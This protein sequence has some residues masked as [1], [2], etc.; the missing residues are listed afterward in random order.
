M[1]NNLR[2]TTGAAYIVEAVKQHRGVTIIYL[3]LRLLDM[4]YDL[5]IFVQ[6]FIQNWVSM[7]RADILERDRLAYVFEGLNLFSVLT[8]LMPTAIALAFF[9]NDDRHIKLIRVAFIVAFS[10]SFVIVLYSVYWSF[11]T[12]FFMDGMAIEIFL[13]VIVMTIVG[14]AIPACLLMVTL[15]NVTNRKIGITL[16]AFIS[17]NLLLF[18]ASTV[19]NGVN[20]LIQS[21]GHLQEI[22]TIKNWFETVKGIFSSIVYSVILILIAYHFIKRKPKTVPQEAGILQANEV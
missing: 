9:L 3:V 18:T 12:L 20:L 21:N 19:V 10:V 5:F 22:M 8:L 15:F 11:Y 7:Y 2:Q 14:L 16:L 1:K 4:V 13:F 17:I 6:S